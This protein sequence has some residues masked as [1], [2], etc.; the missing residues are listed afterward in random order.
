MF[1]SRHIPIRNRREPA[2]TEALV[3]VY[4]SAPSLCPRSENRPAAV[5]AEALICF[6]FARIHAQHLDMF[7]RHREAARA[8]T[9]T[10]AVWPQALPPHVAAGRTARVRPESGGSRPGRGP[11][12][13]L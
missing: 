10:A 6:S 3:C 5:T 1:K 11:S 4:T 2:A 9:S 8:V 13:S 7:S 12:R